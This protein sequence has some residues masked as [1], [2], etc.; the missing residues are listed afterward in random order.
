[1]EQQAWAGK[2]GKDLWKEGEEDRI[3]GRGKRKNASGTELSFGKFSHAEGMR[4]VAPHYHEAEMS[5]GAQLLPPAVNNS[6]DINK[7]VN[8]ACKRPFSSG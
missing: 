1:M 5:H 6:D 7:R 4:Q 3:A 2:Q 8:R